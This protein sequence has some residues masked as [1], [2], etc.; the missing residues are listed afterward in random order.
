[1]SSS[2]IATLIRLCRWTSDERNTRHPDTATLTKCMKMKNLAENGNF[3]TDNE[4]Y[5]LKTPCLPASW[6]AFSNIQGCNSSGF[7]SSIMPSVFFVD[8]LYL[9]VKNR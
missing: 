7:K 6:I 4:N 5:Q 3:A 2:M 9:L 1:M 8:R